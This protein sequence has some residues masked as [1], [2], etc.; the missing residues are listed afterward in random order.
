[1]RDNSPC[2]QKHSRI[3][4]YWEAKQGRTLNKELHSLM[5]VKSARVMQQ[6]NFYVLAILLLSI[7][8]LSF[9][10]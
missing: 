8:Y 7:I 1:V 10:L 4:Q 6:L 9:S 5:T 3:S 2:I